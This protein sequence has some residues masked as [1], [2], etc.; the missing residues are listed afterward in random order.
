MHDLAEL[1]K[2]AAILVYEGYLTLAT[3]GLVT[4]MRDMW[5]SFA[6]AF[7]KKKGWLTYLKELGT[8]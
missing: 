2:V 1:Q 3:V 7:V 8:P 5:L 4:P 6:L